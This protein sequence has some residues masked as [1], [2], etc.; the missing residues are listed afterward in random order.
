MKSRFNLE[1]EADK[2]RLFKNLSADTEYKRT[3]D[4]IQKLS[5]LTWARMYQLALI[6]PEVYMRKTGRQVGLN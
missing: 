5:G 6:S 2:V 3:I 4:D 1:T